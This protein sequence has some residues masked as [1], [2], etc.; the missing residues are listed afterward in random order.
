MCRSVSLRQQSRVGCDNTYLCSHLHTEIAED[1]VASGKCSVNGMA[2]AQRKLLL[3][4]DDE[5]RSRLWT[6]YDD[7]FRCLDAD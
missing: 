5:V 2:L 4:L 3:R 6:S 1:A 7:A